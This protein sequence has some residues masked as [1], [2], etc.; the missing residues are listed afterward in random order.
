MLSPGLRGSGSKR[1]TGAK[2]TLRQPTHAT[3]SVTRAAAADD[4]TLEALERHQRASASSL[5]RR[6]C[7][8]MAVTN[9]RVQGG[10]TGDASRRKGA[11]WYRSRLCRLPTGESQ[12]IQ[13]ALP[14]RSCES[15][16]PL[17]SP[18]PCLCLPS[19]RPR[20]E[21]PP[22]ARA[23]ERRQPQPVKTIAGSTGAGSVCSAWLACSGAAR[24]LTFTGSTRRQQRAAV[25]SRKQQLPVR[26]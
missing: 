12:C 15:L 22:L 24:Q 9:P 18:R 7:A 19:H 25:A 11:V 13:L 8:P 10:G 26:R 14:I 6:V 4:H 21:E 3:K 1:L 2:Y 16:L 20:G 5:E 23:R 17:R